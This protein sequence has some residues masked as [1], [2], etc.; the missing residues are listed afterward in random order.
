MPA[1]L[2]FRGLRP[3][4][5]VT[6]PIDLVV[7]PPYDV[8][9]DEDRAQLE[10]R[11]PYNFVRVEVPRGDYAGAAALLDAWQRSQ[12]WVRD[13]SPALYG[14]RMQY[15]SPTGTTRET[16]GLI[17][18][19]A[20]QPPSGGILPHEQTTP[21]DKTDRLELL[22]A[23][24]AN[25]SP[26]WCLCPEQ[27]LA[28]LA[29]EG[30]D[31]ALVARAVDNDVVHE[32]WPIFSKAAHQQATDLTDAGPLLVAD[33]HH[34]YETALTYQSETAASP[35]SA[36]GSRPESDTIGPGGVLA[37]VVD[38][39]PEQLYVLAVH[40]VVTLLPA[41]SDVKGLLAKAMSFEPARS[42][43]TE[44]LDEMREAGAAALVTPDG[45]FLARPL[46]RQAGTV[47]TGAYQLDSEL[48]DSALA[49]LPP[50]ELRYEH[51]AARAMAQVRERRAD[52][53]VLCRP[54]T[55][56]D[57]AATAK[58]GRRM[59]PKTTFFWP[60]PRSGMVVRA[61]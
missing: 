13:A 59:P 57:I 47:G 3:D 49:T 24:R 39:T 8:V 43:G 52:A 17:G 19:L 12:A 32:L 7:C 29:L 61:W 9:T 31:Q 18:A 55:I 42:A 10:A 30:Y 36:P 51:D 26:I 6:G 23:T 41:G 53:A 37:L 45:A 50:H 44:L 35:L 4:P 2:P 54:P 21:K 40:R 28:K 16:V 33:G 60:K 20:L 5:A 11:S 22:R 56:D 1:L 15:P 25:T 14:Y 48:V 38:L 34:R 58:G 46:P 27:G